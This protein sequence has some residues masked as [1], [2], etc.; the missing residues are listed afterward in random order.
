M[1]GWE[2]GVLLCVL[3]SILFRCPLQAGQRSNNSLHAG[4]GLCQQTESNLHGL[5][6]ARLLYKTTF[7]SLSGS[8]AW[9]ILASYCPREVGGCKGLG[10]MMMQQFH[11]TCHEGPA[12]D[13]QKVTQ[14]RHT[15]CIQR[16]HSSVSVSVRASILPWLSCSTIR[17]CRNTDVFLARDHQSDGHA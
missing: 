1:G 9:S 10:C 2:S 11:I 8:Y 14:S 17:K 3:F 5:N 13:L 15:L 6:K 7:S 16:N 4:G 12:L